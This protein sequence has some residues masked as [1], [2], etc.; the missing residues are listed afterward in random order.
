MTQ[1]TG[2]HGAT[3]DHASQTISLLTTTTGFIDIYVLSVDSEPDWIIPQNLVL[4]TMTVDAQAT[5]VIWEGQQIPLK[6]LLGRSST[7]TQAVAVLLEADNDAERIGVLIDTAPHAMRVRISNLRD[8][9]DSAV[10]Q[11]AYQKVLLA[12]QLYQVPD[13]DRITQSILPHPAA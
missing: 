3:A 6:S 12:D 10:L 7:L 5:V 13:L 4:D 1:K 9:N 8:T 11:Y 2:T